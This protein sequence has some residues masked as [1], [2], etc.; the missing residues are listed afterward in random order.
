MR[1]EAQLFPDNPLGI[2]DG[3]DDLGIGAIGGRGGRRIIG[4]QHKRGLVQL[5]QARIAALRHC[6]R[7]VFAKCRHA[8]CNGLRLIALPEWVDEYIDRQV[9]LA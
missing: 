6:R 8:L 2:R 5:V 9:R 1:P 3:R 7:E 4:R